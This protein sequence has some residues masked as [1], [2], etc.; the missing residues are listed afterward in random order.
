MGNL[1]RRMTKQ[2]GY[3]EEKRQLG[4]S[5][6]SWWSRHI[7]CFLTNVV[8]IV[9]YNSHNYMVS[10]M[11][12]HAIIL[13]IGDLEKSLIYLIN[14]LGFELMYASNKYSLELYCDANVA[15]AR[16]VDLPSHIHTCLVYFEKE[17]KNEVPYYFCFS[18]RH[19]YYMYR[20]CHTWSMFER[21]GWE[22]KGWLKSL[23]IQVVDWYLILRL[24]LI[25]Y[26]YSYE[27]HH[28][29]TSPSSHL[30]TKF[31]WSRLKSWDGASLKSAY[32]VVR[33]LLNSTLVLPLV[34]TCSSV[35]FKKNVGF[36]IDKQTS[37]DDMNK[38]KSNT[39]EW[40]KSNSHHWYCQK[41]IFR[42]AVVVWANVFVT[43]TTKWYNKR[44]KRGVC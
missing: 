37:L 12:K 18:H 5:V 11:T 29:G 25:K 17:I 39:I 2:D 40:Q 19:I 1:K 10:I 23:S 24:H 4:I 38:T 28:L 41:N 3:I 43:S 9:N 13:L 6:D 26:V 27:P 14:K 36:S 33:V 42:K 16:D 22:M 21:K 32:Y 30:K 44:I 31:A 15:R 34:I 8:Y 7:K 20:L 35:I